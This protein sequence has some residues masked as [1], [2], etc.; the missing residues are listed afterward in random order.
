MHRK[1][2]DESFAIPEA[3]DTSSGCARSMSKGESGLYA[4]ARARKD[5]GCHP[6]YLVVRCGERYVT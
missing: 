5:R 2:G 3:Q 1:G 4:K 6:S